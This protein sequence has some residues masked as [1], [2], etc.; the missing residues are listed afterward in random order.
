MLPDAVMLQTSVEGSSHHHHRTLIVAPLKQRASN[1][2]TLRAQRAPSPTPRTATPSISTNQAGR[3]SL[4]LSLKEMKKEKYASCRE[5]GKATEGSTEGPITKQ[6]SIWHNGF[7]RDY[8]RSRRSDNWAWR[9]VRLSGPRLIGM[10]A[11]SMICC[12]YLGRAMQCRSYW[13]LRCTRFSSCRYGA[14]TAGTREE[15]IAV[16]H[17]CAYRH[18][19]NGNSVR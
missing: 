9:Y 7:A 12:S 11:G 14:Y 13:P 10:L 8:A 18:M 4:A 17:A 2:Q 5:H 19:H 16:G 1:A 15:E 3:T 6:L